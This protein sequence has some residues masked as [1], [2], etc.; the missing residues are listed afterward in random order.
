MKT[1]KVFLTLFVAV[2]LISCNRD[3]A[4]LVDSNDEI[5]NSNGKSGL[6]QGGCTK[7]QDGTIVDNSGNIIETGYDQWGYNYQAHI[8]NGY[9][10]NYT[11]PST[12]VTSGDMLIMKWNDIWLANTDCDGDN[13]LDRGNACDEPYTSSACPG[14]WVTNHITWYDENGKKCTYFC[15]IVCPESDS[16]KEDGIFYTVDGDEIGPVI[17]GSFAII[18]EIQTGPDKYKYNS[19]IGPGFGKSKE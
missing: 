7:I 5:T 13:K 18:Q 1:L 12:L 6:I 15:K 14:A 2:L 4:N 11:R 19:P 17:W 8:F 3:T 16:Y 9:Y 10:G